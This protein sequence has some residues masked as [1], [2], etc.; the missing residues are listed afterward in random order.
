M[1]TGLLTLGLFLVPK[2]NIVLEELK[3]EGGLG[4]LVLA[5]LVEKIDSLLEGLVCKFDSLCLLADDLI[6]ENGVVEGKTEV[7]WVGLGQ[8]SGGDGHSALVGSLSLGSTFLPL[9]FWLEFDR[10]PV[11]VS[12]ELLVEDL[13]GGVLSILEELA[14]GKLDEVGAEAVELV[15]E[16]LLEVVEFLD[17]LGVAL[18]AVVIEEG[19]DG[20]EGGTAGAGEGLVSDRKKVALITVETVLVV[21]DLVHLSEDILVALSLVG[22]AGHEESKFTIERHR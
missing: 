15:D 21:D 5:E 1:F 17:T 8:F 14:V 3:D 20:A 9:L 22:D 2:S 12:L 6:K 11:V 7:G 13:G 19:V 10:V 18:D 4:V 16:L